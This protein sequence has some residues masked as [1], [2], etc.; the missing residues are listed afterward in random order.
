ML[1]KVFE[2]TRVANPSPTDELVKKRSASISALVDALEEDQSL[3]F[4]Y[5]AAAVGGL[6]P[7][8]SQDSHLVVSVLKAVREEQPAFPENLAEN[9]VDL[10]VCCAL[11]IGEVLDRARASKTLPGDEYLAASALVVS[12]IHPQGSGSNRYFRQMLVELKTT[13]EAVAVSAGRM[14]RTRYT[15][16]SL[17][18]GLKEVPEVPAF[19]Q[20]LHPKLKLVIETLEENARIDREEIDALW[21]AFNRFSTIEQ[22]AYPRLPTGLAAL[23]CGLELGNMTLLPHWPNMPALAA[24][25]LGEGR[26]KQDMTEKAL[27]DFVAEWTSGSVA[28]LAAPS[29]KGAAFVRSNPTLLPLSW[30]CLLQTEHNNSSWLGELK[31]R[32]SWDAQKRIS[33]E[34]IASQVFIERVA[35]RLMADCEE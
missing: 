15:A 34:S 11:V 26:S 32:A 29:D 5:V 1:T 23:C 13:A 25:M 3:L 31:K 27:A 4:D 6:V 14:K 9:N 33:A 17:L 21:W 18:D 35:R 10:R 8:F 22:T 12:G 30:G 7:R 28:A 2:W 19:W 16:K 20:G 24:R